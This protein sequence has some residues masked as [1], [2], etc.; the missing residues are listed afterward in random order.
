MIEDQQKAIT[1]R[2]NQTQAIQNENVAL[3]AQQ[4]VYQTHLKRCQGQIYDIT[5]KNNTP[6]EIEF[7]E[8][9]C[10]IARMQELPQKDKCVE[11]NIHTIGSS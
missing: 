10:Y 2:D 3:A 1:D 4:D 9:S 7:Y 8:Y 5:E 11:H 6:Y